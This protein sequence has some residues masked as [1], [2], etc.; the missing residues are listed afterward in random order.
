MAMPENFEWRSCGLTTVGAVRKHNEDAYLAL[1]DHQ[2]WLVADG[3]GGHNRGDLASS[4][5]VEA[6]DDFEPRR[7]L[8]QSID[9]IEDRI[10]KVNKVLR[11]TA[12]SDPRD[13]SGS[14]IALM[15]GHQQN[16][17]FFWAGDSRIYL[18]RNRRLKMLSHDHSFVQEAV[19]KG[20]I[21]VEDAADH[22]SGNIITR[23]VG[24][25]D[26]LYMD[27]DYCQ[28]KPGDKFLLCSDGLLK[29]TKTHEISSAMEQ[30]P[31]KAAE[32]M[33]DICLS[34]NVSDNVTV[35]VIEAFSKPAK[36]K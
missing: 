12:G 23:A 21:K 4:S 20:T 31:F 29:A 7:T 3:M 15:H 24:V 30:I 14:T 19:D 34:R 11:S 26:E 27:I 16:A 36:L 8:T 9:D 22:P 25:H 1:P 10:L 2:L 17:F 32:R 5:I 35:I 33:I 18:Y 28:V 6:F 13:I